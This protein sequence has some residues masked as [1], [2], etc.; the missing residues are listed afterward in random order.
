MN[1]AIAMIIAIAMLLPCSAAMA[2]SKKKLTPGEESGVKLMALVQKGYINIYMDDS[3]PLIYVEPKFW[4]MG[5]HLDKH[6][7]CV[8]ALQFFKELDTKEGKKRVCINFKDMTSKTELANVEVQT[9]RIEIY[10]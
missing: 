9:G 8:N 10:R 2:A 6:N 1:K 3:C 5:K 7:L 4:A